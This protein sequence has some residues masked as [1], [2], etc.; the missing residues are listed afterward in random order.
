MLR[1]LVRNV[2]SFVT[3]GGHV[4]V[5]FRLPF[6][7]FSLLLCWRGKIWNRRHEI[8]QIKEKE[9]EEGEPLIR[10]WYPKYPVLL[11]PHSI[12]RPLHSAKNSKPND[13]SKVL[14]WKEIAQSD[15]F[16]CSMLQS[17]SCAGN[18]FSEWQVI[19]GG[20]FGGKVTPRSSRAT[21]LFRVVN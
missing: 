14:R 7:I 21:P 5:F 18:T 6:S 12:C 1:E 15:Q 16:L 8:Q 13:S 4:C 11:H 9:R 20:C 2:V 10:T 3:P 17:L 19:D